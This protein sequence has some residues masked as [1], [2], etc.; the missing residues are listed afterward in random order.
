MSKVNERSNGSEN[1]LVRPAKEFVNLNLIRAL[2]IAMVVISHLPIPKNWIPDRY[3]LSSLGSLG[4]FIFFLHTATVLMMS[5]DRQRS[6]GNDKL[7]R[8]FFIRRIMRIYPLSIVA[9]LIISLVIICSGGE[10]NLITFSS[11]LLLIQNL[12][13]TPSIPP[14]LWSLPYEVQMYLVLP[15]I[16]LILIKMPQGK[17]YILLATWSV[18]IVIIYGGTSYGFNLDLIKFSPLF[19]SGVITYVLYDALRVKRISPIFLIIYCTALLSLFP[20]IVGFGVISLV[21]GWP[22]VLLLG[23]LLS[24]S[25]EVKDQ[26]IVVFSKVLAQYSYAIYLIHFPLIDLVFNRIGLDLSLF[27]WTLFFLLLALLSYIFHRWVELPC[28]RMGK[29]WT[30]T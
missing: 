4:V 6:E 24:I 20:V 1:Y 22:I 15:F 8:L 14:T 5:L 21:L 13:H 25:A 17:F 9:V 29:K 18:A 16:F 26:T 2:A 27:K 23:V 30:A 10:L 11:N 3:D 12:T 28:I 19:I 7:I